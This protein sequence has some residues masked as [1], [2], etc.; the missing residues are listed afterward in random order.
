MKIK[1]TKLNGVFII[2]MSVFKD[3]R[4]S[5]TKAFNKDFFKKNNIT[6]DNFEES[7]FSISHKNVIR[8]MHFQSPPKDNEKLIYVTNG[9]ILDVVLDIKK[10][11]PTYGKYISTKISDKNRAAI[12]IPKGFAHGFLSL[13]K[14]TCVIYL[15]TTVHSQEHYVGIKMDSFGMNWGVKKPIVSKRDQDFQKFNEFLTPFIY[16]K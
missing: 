4:G 6:T 8:G 7:Y 2:K 11:S 5:F 15:Q 3:G 14:N 1:K 13:E 16:K 9:S 10:G 12:F